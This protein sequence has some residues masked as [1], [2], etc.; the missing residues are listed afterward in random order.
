[1]KEN[2]PL[3]FIIF[4]AT[5]D[6]AKK[7]LLPSLLDLYCKDLL[8]EKFTIVGFSR[9]DL[10]DDDYREFTMNTFASSG[11]KHPKNKVK[12]F[13][14]RIYYKQGDLNKVES[15]RDLNDYIVALDKKAG[16]CSNKIFYL[17]VPPRL[18]NST[19]INLHESKLSET[20]V[21]GNEWTRILVEKPF[22]SNV[23]EAR[24]LDKTLGKFF[25]EN[26]IFRIDH[27]LAK[28]TIQNILTFRFANAIFEPLWNNK[29][30]EK[31]E[32]I[33]HETEDASARAGF[34][35][36]IGALR[37]VGQNHLLQMLAA[38]TMKDPKGT[39]ADKIRKARFDAISKVALPSGA[40][41]NYALRAQY[42]GYSE[43]DGAEDK[44]KTETFFKVKL[45]VNDRA[46]RGVPI[47]LESGKALNEDLTEI[48]ITFKDKES[49]VCPIN[50]VCKYSNVLTIKIKPTEEISIL[51]WK[52]KAGLDFGVEQK[53]IAFDYKEDSDPGASAYSKVL[54]DCIKG[55]L[56]L[57]TST[58]EVATQWRII[59]EILNRWKNLPLIKYKEGETAEN[60]K[61]N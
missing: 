49:F 20:C 14:G 3:T 15:Y 57:F 51:F 22:G 36:D 46:W 38:V 43:H 58:E 35:D 61:N 60:I 4:G 40:I 48:R 59:T 21:V 50:D 27:Y 13:L 16:L 24:H 33:M 55:D 10:S 32:I 28:E 18:Y 34:Y 19:F 29:Y 42:E 47:Y 54:Y 12:D 7:K 1:M 6:L 8:P 5:G 39:S 41:E 2:K 53:K 25:S 31:V 23:D 11:E 52:K 30:I 9:K 45:L 26:Q 56:T 17:A 44:S 37:D